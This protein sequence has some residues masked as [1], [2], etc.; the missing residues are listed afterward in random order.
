M[1]AVLQ[2][3]RLPKPENCPNELYE[4]MLKC[5]NAV[6]SQR[7]TFQDLLNDLLNFSK[8]IQPENATIIHIDQREESGLVYENSA[9]ESM[10]HNKRES[11]YH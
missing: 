6:P 9:F 1:Q 3:E 11:M 8:T 5:W 4:I 10:Y 7:P 2:G